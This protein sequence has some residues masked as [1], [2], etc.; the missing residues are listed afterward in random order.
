MEFDPRTHTLREE[1]SPSRYPLIFMCVQGAHGGLGMNVCAC[2]GTVNK[3]MGV[4]KR[5]NR[6]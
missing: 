6:G 4:K 2:T 5:N 3:C 1:L